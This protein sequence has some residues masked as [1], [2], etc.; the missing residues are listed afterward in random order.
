M[1]LFRVERGLRP[2]AGVP[3]HPL[4]HPTHQPARPLL[5]V[6]PAVGAV[7]GTPG[8]R[9]GGAPGGSEGQKRLP[10]WV[11]TLWPHGAGVSWGAGQG[12]NR[13]ARLSFL[14]LCPTQG[15]LSTRCLLTLSRTLTSGGYCCAHFP[16]EQTE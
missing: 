13:G 11:T 10:W 3:P 9:P 8:P 12:G 1:W 16:D 14:S 4:P 2:E 7:D 15:A 5:T 6:Q